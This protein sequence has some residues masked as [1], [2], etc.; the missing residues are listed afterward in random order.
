MKN[1]K[2]LIWCFLLTIGSS[3]CGNVIS[4]AL[5]AAKLVKPELVA[6]SSIIA[7]ARIRYTNDGSSA[8]S[9]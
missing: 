3:A 2:L 9:Y 7:G 4:S 1:L 5:E 6:I 8:R